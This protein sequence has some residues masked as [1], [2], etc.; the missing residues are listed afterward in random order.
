MKDEEKTREQLI[1]E[2][3]ALRARL[4]TPGQDS[5]G[6]DL[7]AAPN[8]SLP[9]KNGDARFRILFEQAPEGIFLFDGRVL[10]DCNEAMLKMMRCSCKGELLGRHPSAFSPQLQPDGSLSREKADS[11]MAQALQTGHLQQEW[12]CRR[13][14]GEEFPVEILLTVI[15]WEGKPILYMVWRDI[16][17]RRRIEDAIRHL[18]YHDVLTGL[19]NRILFTDRMVLAIAQAKRYQ[20]TMAVMMLDLDRFKLI[21]DTRG[22]HIGD[23]LLQA[24]GNRLNRTLREEDTVAR[25]GGDEFM[26]LL[27]EIKE[28]ESSCY[29]ARKIVS[30]FAKPFLCEGE[31]LATSAS[32]GIAVYPEDG[33][34]MDTLMR[35]ADMAMYQ[36]KS[37]GRNTYC[38]YSADLTPNGGE[39][40][41]GGGARER[42]PASGGR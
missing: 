18:A 9:E 40:E 3:A 7:S 21:N 17:E 35:H 36:A 42:T 37:T 26:I 2:L 33:D 15:P 29:V 31:D 1:Q 22:H 32:V 34:D 6:W 11:W 38:R 5:G 20:K 25:L 12:L 19:P 30:A 13:L 10:I 14:D 28:P 27:Q 23:Q 16:T 8:R 41:A 4:S 39:T 24:V